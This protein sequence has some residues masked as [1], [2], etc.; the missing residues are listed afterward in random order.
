MATKRTILIVEDDEE[1]RSALV[2]PIAARLLDHQGRR[3]E[4]RQLGRAAIGADG[5]PAATLG[6]ALE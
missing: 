4:R 3:Q 2:E 1:L 6:S 5:R